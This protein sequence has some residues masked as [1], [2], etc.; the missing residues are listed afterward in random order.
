MKKFA[1]VLWLVAPLGMAAWLDAHEGHQHKA[2]G[3]VKAIDATQVEIETQD[4][5]R[6][7]VALDK[8]TKFLKGKTAV[9][10]SELKV[11]DRAV[12]V[13]VD[14]KE[15]KVARQVLLGVPSSESHKH[16]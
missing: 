14:E 4:G 5:K 9:A 7:S 3:V 1:L 10:A 8:D 11:G 2:M 12:L 16:D 13:Y 15:K 6:I